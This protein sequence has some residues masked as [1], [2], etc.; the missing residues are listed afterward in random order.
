MHQMEA[1]ASDGYWKH[2]SDYYLTDNELVTMAPRGVRSY[3]TV[4]WNPLP[5]AGPSVS[6]SGIPESDQDDTMP[7]APHHNSE[8]DHQ[9]DDDGNPGPH[10]RNDDDDD[11]HMSDASSHLIAQAEEAFINIDDMA[12]I[13]EVDM[14]QD[15][16][17]PSFH[18]SPIDLTQDS[19]SEENIDDADESDEDELQ[20]SFS[21]NRNDESDPDTGREDEA[22][23]D[24][25]DMAS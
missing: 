20:Q 21:D 10:E 13:E 19:T 8:T 6:A 24:L 18:N 1:M 12:Y 7:T 23:S 25:Y 17:S 14:T 2:P 5:D 3:N 22:T 9:L 15:D 4:A 16:A 11:V